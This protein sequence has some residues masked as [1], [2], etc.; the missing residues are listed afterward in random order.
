MIL[1]FQPFE[2][3]SQVLSK[4]EAYIF[5][6]KLFEVQIL[7]KNG[8]DILKRK[9][10]EDKFERDKRPNLNNGHIEVNSDLSISHL[11]IYLSQAFG[12]DLYYRSGILEQNKIIREWQKE[13]PKTS[14]I[15]D[16]YSELKPK[17]DSLFEN[18]IGTKIEEKIGDEESFP[19]ETLNISFSM[20]SFPVMKEFDLINHSRSVLG[21]TCSRTLEDIFAIGL[22]DE[23]V[24]KEVKSKIERN[25]ITLETYVLNYA[26]QRVVFYEDFEE[27]K[28][29]ELEFIK[30]LRKSKIISEINYEKLTS[31]KNDFV[32]L[33]KY[34]LIKYCRNARIFHVDQYSKNPS[35]GYKQI[36]QEIITILP[37]FK[38]TDF[39][40]N[41]FKVE[42]EWGSDL[43]EYRANI[44]FDV[45]GTKYFNDFFYDYKKLDVE[46]VDT[47]LKINNDFHK[48][49]NKYLAD[50]DSEYRLYYANKW[51]EGKG[52]YGAGEFGL[53][54]LT[55]KQFKAWGTSNSDYF[56]FDQNHGNKFNSKN[57]SELISEYEGIGLF[58]HLSD[59]EIEK[60]KDCVSNVEID[61][62]Q[63]ILLCFPKTIVYFDWETGNLENPY[64]ELTIS[65]KDASR[66]IFDPMNIID[67]FEKSW[68]KETVNYSFQLNDKKYEEKL[69]MHSDWL[70]PAFMELIDR[71]IEESNVNGKIYWCLDNGQAAGYIIL[72]DEQYRY[73][74]ENQSE[75]FP[76]F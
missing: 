43:V 59:L 40:A 74:K 12:S 60:A 36:F 4:E 47:I 28:L 21:K 45:A 67:E 5:A 29:K 63:S 55:E 3:V 35:I 33:E 15:E 34:D 14:L 44:R 64:E 76:G 58:S 38:F 73:L 25:E 26:A 62:Y 27:N 8:Q 13:N 75:L 54:L 23:K 57:I 7:N 30:L 56:L 42:D 48:G 37:Q 31:R 2:L 51:E 61:S 49:V 17:L 52:V 70:D 1:F 71:S 16:P 72:N 24:Y 32:L 20:F 22:I 68:E 66:G 9:I 11:L 46:E 18:F 65:F 10:D 53:I 6:D 50:L 19:K 39:E 69:K 41:V